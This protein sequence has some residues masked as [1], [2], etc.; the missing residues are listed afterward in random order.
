[1][2]EELNRKDRK[3]IPQRTQRKDLSRREGAESNHRHHCRG[4]GSAG[5]AV[6]CVSGKSLTAKIA[7]KFRR[8]PKEK[9]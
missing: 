2:R 1:L 6:K 9:T 7:K 3:E 5:V 4:P 8:G